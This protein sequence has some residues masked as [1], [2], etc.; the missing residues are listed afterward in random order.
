MSTWAIARGVD[1]PWELVAIP[2]TSAA[3][4]A[5]LGRDAGER[6]NDEGDVLVELDTELGRATVDVVAVDR[7]RERLVLE[8]LPD[9]RGLQTGDDA[10]RPDEGDRVHEAGEL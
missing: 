8:L 4:E 3:A 6:G 5:D 10:S 2:A 1:V 9:R 7:A